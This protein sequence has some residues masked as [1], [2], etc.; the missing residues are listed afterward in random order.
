MNLI[1]HYIATD[2][3]DPIRASLYEFALAQNGVFLRAERRGL[4][5]QFPI[6]EGSSLRGGLAKLD[7]CIAL[8]YPR[9]PA[10]LLNT[11]LALSWTA[12]IPAPKE[13]LFHLWFEDGW[14]FCRPPQ[15][16]SYA[17]VSPLD[18]GPG[19]SYAKAMVEVHSHHNLPVSAKFSS[20]DDADERGFRIYAVLGRI[21]SRPQIRVRVGVYGYYYEVPAATLF[22]LPRLIGDALTDPDQEAESQDAQRG[23]DNSLPAKP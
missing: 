11:M 18:D 2:P 20:I 17:G 1:R 7:P 15:S 6:M 14:Q 5:V 13:I 3:D 16:Q 23:V 9:I 4:R 19:S 21:F 10:R 8:E 22:E 12:C